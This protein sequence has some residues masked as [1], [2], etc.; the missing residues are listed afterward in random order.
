MICNTFKE[1]KWKPHFFWSG[2][3]QAIK[4]PKEFRLKG[5]VADIR[6]EGHKIIIQEKETLTWDEFFL[7][8]RHVLILN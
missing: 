4:L 2:N 6:R 7:N 1:C 8:M 5:T 3:S